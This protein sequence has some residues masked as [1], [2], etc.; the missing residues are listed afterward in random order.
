MDWYE[1][2]FDI[3]GDNRRIPFGPSTK[4]EYTLGITITHGE[5]NLTY[6]MPDYLQKV[7]SDF[8]MTDCKPSKTPLPPGFQIF[9]ADQPQTDEERAETTAFMTKAFGN[10]T[11][12]YKQTT[13]FYSSLLQSLN[14]FARMVCPTLVTAVS[15]LASATHQP[16][17][18]AIKAIKQALRYSKS[19]MNDGLTYTR[20]RVYAK[21]E[22]PRQ[23]YSSDSSFHDHIESGKS[24]GGVVG[25]LDDLAVTYFRAGRSTHVTT[26]SAHAESYQAAEAAKQIMYERQLGFELGFDMPV[27]LLYMDNAAVIAASTA[28]LRQF[29]QRMK[30]YLLSERYLTQCVESGVI[31]VLYKNTSDIDADAMTKALPSATLQRHAHTLE[32]GYPP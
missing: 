28:E 7:L 18:K 31:E 3:T 19:K 8:N 27:A 30:H 24:H 5:T 13:K 25:R 26:C 29:S 23:I 16:S 6:R 20:R 17:I 22:F 11:S 32:Y 21:H 2:R 15:I 4:P 14:W 12:G 1:S 10:F 9:K